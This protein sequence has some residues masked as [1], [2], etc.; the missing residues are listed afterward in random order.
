MEPTMEPAHRTEAYKMVWMIKV[1]I[2]SHRK[3]SNAI[4]KKWL[5]DRTKRKNQTGIYI[6][7]ILFMIDKGPSV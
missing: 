7:K 1:I 3:I 2:I 5:Y 6:P 4:E